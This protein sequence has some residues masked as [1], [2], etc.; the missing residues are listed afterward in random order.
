MAQ[1]KITE[2]QLISSVDD[3]LLFAADNG[4]QTYR[5]SASQIATYIGK[6]LKWPITSKTTTYTAVVADSRIMVTTA[7][8]WTLTLFAASGN[9]G[10]ILT[11]KKT[12]SDANALTI[13]GNGSE[14]IDGATTIKIWNQNESVSIICDGSNWHV[15]ERINNSRIFVGYVA[16]NQSLTADVTN[17]PLTSQKDNAGGWGGSSYTVQE[18]GDYIVIGSFINNSGTGT[19]YSWI[20]G[21]GA[22][23]MASVST[24]AWL[25]GSVVW[26]GCVVGDVLS[27]RNNQSITALGNTGSNVSIRKIS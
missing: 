2:L 14:T 7:S 22:R 4:T 11:I 26:P 18:A 21:T 10:K 25:G 13:D 8:A 27:I 15:I 17:L 6:S 19:Y 16:S 24:T 9:A 1:K 20:N 5:T 12:S 3:A 23:A